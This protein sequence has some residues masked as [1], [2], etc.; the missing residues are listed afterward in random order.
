M[1]D[2]AEQEAKRLLLELDPV[3]PS[4]DHSWQDNWTLPHLLSKD[5]RDLGWLGALQ[6]KYVKG[7]LEW[8][9][10]V[11][12]K[13]DALQ[14]EVEKAQRFAVKAHAD[15]VA[16][17]EVAAKVLRERDGLMFA[18]TGRLKRTEEQIA[19][20]KGEWPNKDYVRDEAWACLQQ[21]VMTLKSILF[22]AAHY[23]PEAEA[24]L[25]TAK[26]E[27]ATATA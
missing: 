19:R 6:S 7:L 20:G 2:T 13:Q 26:G 9:T 15:M 11:V 18:I 23:N 5:V 4:V 16:A 27:L 22:A 1:P 24:A 17:E 12:R 10:G 21:E 8:A 3:V 25:A 14:A